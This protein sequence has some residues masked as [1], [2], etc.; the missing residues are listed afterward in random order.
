M[1]KYDFERDELWFSRRALQE[2]ACAE[3]R[4]FCKHIEETM[5]KKGGNT[6]RQDE[7]YLLRLEGV[8]MIHRKSEIYDLDTSYLIMQNYKR[9]VP[10]DYKRIINRLEELRE[11]VRNNDLIGLRGRSGFA[12]DFESRVAEDRKL[13]DFLKEQNGYCMTKKR[14]IFDFSSNGFSFVREDEE[15]QKDRVWPRTLF[16]ER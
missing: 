7:V 2:L 10:P 5:N 14:V 8:R 4:N 3:R 12:E 15:D 16:C 9:S 1:K 6:W 11:I 13:L